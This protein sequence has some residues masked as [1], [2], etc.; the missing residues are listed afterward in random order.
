MD[1]LNDNKPLCFNCF[2]CIFLGI[3][4]A[5]LSLNKWMNL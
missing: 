1:N 2:I 5:S 3:L 4:K